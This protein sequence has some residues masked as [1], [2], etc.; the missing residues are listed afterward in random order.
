MSRMD[1]KKTHKTHMKNVLKS[2]FIYL[3]IVFF[4]VLFWCPYMVNN[5]VSVQQY[6]GGFLPEIIFLTL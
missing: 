1:G 2:N 3:M 6:N 4:C 5:V